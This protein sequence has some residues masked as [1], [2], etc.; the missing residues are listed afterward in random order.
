MK[1][2]I[3]VGIYSR[4]NRTYGLTFVSFVRRVL[5]AVTSPSCVGQQ[6]SGHF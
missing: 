5:L 1:Y 4:H 2:E 6:W 3:V